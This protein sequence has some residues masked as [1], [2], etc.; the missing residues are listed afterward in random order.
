MLNLNYAPNTS[1][2]RFILFFFFFFSFNKF[3]GK[4]T[5]GLNQETVLHEQGELFKFSPAVLCIH[6]F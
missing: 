4:I 2:L 1:L 5:S 6:L 3:D